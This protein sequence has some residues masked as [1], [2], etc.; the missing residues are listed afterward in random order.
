MPGNEDVVRIL[1]RE[2]LRT[3]ENPNNMAHGLY[4]LVDDPRK[5]ELPGE[6]AIAQ[7]L[8]YG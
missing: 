4:Q 3:H 6:A 7:S 2:L 8:A 1:P 5:G